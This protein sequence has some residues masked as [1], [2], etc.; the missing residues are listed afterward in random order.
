MPGEEFLSERHARLDSTV[1]YNIPQHNIH[2]LKFKFLCKLSSITS[3]W[4]NCTGKQIL[5]SLTENLNRSLY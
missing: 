4:E 5:I 2:I 1:K 3:E